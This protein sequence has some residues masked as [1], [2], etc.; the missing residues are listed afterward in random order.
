M[1]KVFLKGGKIIN[2]SK[3]GFVHIHGFG[4]WVKIKLQENDYFEFP[5]EQI[6]KIEFENDKDVWED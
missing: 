2:V 5:T 4:K 3:D 1:T 6:I